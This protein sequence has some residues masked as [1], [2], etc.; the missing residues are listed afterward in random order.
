[1]ANYRTYVLNFWL[2]PSKMS[3]LTTISIVKPS[4]KTE[5]IL[6]WAGFFQ[7]QSQMVTY[8]N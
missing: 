5:K 6:L 4:H 1:M 8:S 2:D 3:G 7:I